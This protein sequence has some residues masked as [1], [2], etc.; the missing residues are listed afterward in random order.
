MQRQTSQ[1][2]P[3]KLSKQQQEK[4]P[5]SLGIVPYKS[6]S[7]LV[8]GQVAKTHKIRN[9]LLSHRNMSINYLPWQKP[10]LQNVN[11]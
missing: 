6:P 7:P 8:F 2:N 3:S 4:L 5:L 10:L 11:V 9:P 1:R